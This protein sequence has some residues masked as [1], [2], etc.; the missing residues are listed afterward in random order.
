[1]SITIS[2]YL[3]K[4]ILIL[5]G[6]YSLIGCLLIKKFTKQNC[7]S[8]LLLNYNVC[9]GVPSFLSSQAEYATETGMFFSLSGITM[10]LVFFCHRKLTLLHLGFL[11]CKS[12]GVEFI[13]VKNVRGYALRSPT[14]TLLPPLGPPAE[15]LNEPPPC[16]ASPLTHGALPAGVKKT[17]AVTHAPLPATLAAS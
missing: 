2:Q 5:S 17:Q 11:I 9:N 6:S 8:I 7:F 13:H 16:D 3:V 10:D 14:R 1:M 15:Q 12:E 4:I